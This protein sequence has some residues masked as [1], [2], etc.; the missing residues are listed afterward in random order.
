LGEEGEA[1]VTATFAPEHG[2]TD[3]EAGEG[4][5][6]VNERF[7]EGRRQRD[8]PKSPST[9]P[10]IAPE[11]SLPC[12][13]VPMLRPSPACSLAWRLG[14]ATPS[15]VL[16][17]SGTVG[18]AVAVVGNDVPVNEVT[19]SSRLLVEAVEA[20]VIEGAPE[21]SVMV[22]PDVEEGGGGGGLFLSEWPLFPL[23]GSSWSDSIPSDSDSGSSASLGG[24][25]SSSPAPSVTPVATSAPAVGNG[26]SLTPLPDDESPT[27]TEANGG[28][29]VAVGSVSGSESGSVSDSSS[30]E[31]TESADSSPEVSASSAASSSSSWRRARRAA[32]RS[33]LLICSQAWL[34]RRTVGLE[35]LMMCVLVVVVP[36]SSMSQP[37]V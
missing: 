22:D 3:E 29:T 8:I 23:G 34:R 17:V 33:R 15:C 28:R 1:A 11:L 25:A 12:V 35:T 10:A 27:D 4:W 6:S 24:A 20:D 37:R 30:D 13:A 21:L 16:P 5:M 36:P 2:S 19:R 7:D 14:S 32:R 26:R 18:D 31:S 9:I